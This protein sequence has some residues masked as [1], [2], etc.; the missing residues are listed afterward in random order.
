LR[1]EIK[2]VRNEVAYAPVGPSWYDSGSTQRP[3]QASMMCI[4]L[5]SCSGWAAGPRTATPRQG[6]EAHGHAL[7]LARQF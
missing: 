3:S 5:S 1:A 2:Q 7:G 4:S 6:L